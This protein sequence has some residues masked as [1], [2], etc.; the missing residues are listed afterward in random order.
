MESNSTIHRKPVYEDRILIWDNKKQGKKIGIDDYA[1]V[2][3]AFSQN[4]FQ[5]PQ[6]ANG[7]RLHDDDKIYAKI[8][9][10]NSFNNIAPPN[11]SFAEDGFSIGDA[12]FKLLVRNENGE[13]VEGIF[14][15]HVTNNWHE[16][17]MEQ[18]S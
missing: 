8:C 4:T 9:T 3:I 18:I 2:Y 5:I 7:I 15:I 6:F 17:S 14:K 10:L 1:L 12:H 16:L 13:Y 11:I